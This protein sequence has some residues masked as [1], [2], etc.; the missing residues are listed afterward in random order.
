MQHAKQRA[1]AQQEKTVSYLGRVLGV[2][3]LRRRATVVLGRTLLVVS[4]GGHFRRRET[5]ETRMRCVGD[6]CA[7][8]KGERMRRDCEEKSRRVAADD[9]SGRER[10]ER[11]IR[12]E[13]G[14]GKLESRERIWFYFS[15]GWDQQGPRLG[16]GFSNRAN[17]AKLG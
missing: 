16:P 4:L 12:E 8:A 9:R 17:S 6:E 7:E 15:R 14:V 1:R 2:A 3:L 11:K 5:T 10:G 13:M